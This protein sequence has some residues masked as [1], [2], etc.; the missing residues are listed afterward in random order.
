MLQPG[1]GFMA[2]NATLRQLL[3]SAFNERPFGRAMDIIGAPDWID[4]ARFDIVAKAA[5]NHVIDPD[6]TPRR[7]WLM[8]RSL[9]MDRFKLKAHRESRD[10]PIYALVL[11]RPDG[12]LGSKLRKS[13]VDC[14]AVLEEMSKGRK[15]TIEPGKGP[16]CSIGTPPDRLVTSAITLS[17]FADVLSSRVGR[18]VVDRTGLTGGYNAELEFTED[19]SLANVHSGAVSNPAGGAPSIFTALQE[20]LG[21]KLESTRGPVD[22]LVVDHV[23]RPTED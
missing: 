3:G 17:P 7:S 14:R 10:A 15:P 12:R 18:A 22:V 9:L 19:R 2:T 6:G 8:V 13:D 23:E 1:G 4:S 5:E 20:Q 11:A 16:P 21:L